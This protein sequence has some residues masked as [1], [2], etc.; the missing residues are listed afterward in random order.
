MVRLK[1]LEP[2]RRFQR[3]H[4]KVISTR[5]YGHKKNTMWDY[6]W[7]TGRTGRLSCQ[8]L[9]KSELTAVPTLMRVTVES[10]RLAYATAANGMADP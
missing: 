9:T 5:E 1:G 3:Y 10:A 4:L 6:K 2:S 8:L 7:N